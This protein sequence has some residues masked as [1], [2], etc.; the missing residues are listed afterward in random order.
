MSLFHTSQQWPTT[1]PAGGR[2]VFLR[3]DERGLLG[4]SLES[5]ASY[6][7]S[8]GCVKARHGYAQRCSCTCWLRRRKPASF[9]PFVARSARCN[10]ALRASTRLRYS[11]A[12]ARLPT[13][14]LR[15]RHASA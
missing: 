12:L 2:G 8:A 13:A 7:Q 6:L 3:V 15:N 10:E 4:N 11:G 5:L 1:F 14:S 9:G